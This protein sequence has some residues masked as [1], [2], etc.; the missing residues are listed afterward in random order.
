MS[1]HGTLVAEEHGVRRSPHWPT[2]EKHFLAAHPRCSA[3]NDDQHKARVAQVGHAA[4]ITRGLQVHHAIIPFHYAILL[5]RSDLELDDRNLD[6]FCEN[7]AGIKTEDHHNL[8]GHLRNFQSYN[9]DIPGS[10]RVYRGF[11]HEQLIANSK[12]LALCAAL[13]KKWPELSESERAA[14]R[15]TLDAKLPKK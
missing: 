14:L 11:T 15:K 1:I 13:P 10:L 4:L 5:G 12:F 9:P 3:C 2:V 6:V 8:V 7:E